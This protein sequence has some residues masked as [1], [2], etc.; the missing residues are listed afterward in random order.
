MSQN[1]LLVEIR[2]PLPDSLKEQSSIM[3]TVFNA[4]EG[5]FDA[6]NDALGENGYAHRT[7]TVKRR[8]PRK[9]GAAKPGRKPKAASNGVSD[10]DPAMAAK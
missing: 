5:F 9:E 3:N 7:E 1:E 2:V 4:S 8:E 6:L 10:Y